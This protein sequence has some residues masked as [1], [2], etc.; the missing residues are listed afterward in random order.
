MTFTRTLS[1]KLLLTIP[2]MLAMAIGLTF[3]GDAHFVTLGHAWA[4][5]LI[6]YA[7]LLCSIQIYVWA[8]NVLPAKPIISYE[9]TAKVIETTVTDEQLCMKCGRNPPIQD[10]LCE[11]CKDQVVEVY[12]R[13]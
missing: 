9:P 1:S 10:G 7:F 11:E 4:T 12:T 5:I 6:P 3:L 2:M 13:P 8:R